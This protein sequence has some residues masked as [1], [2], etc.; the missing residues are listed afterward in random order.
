MAG[1]A[2]LVALVLSIATA[3]SPLGQAGV[4]QEAA[5]AAGASPQQP[6]AAALHQERALALFQPV[7]H[8][9]FSRGC[10]TRDLHQVTYLGPDGS[11]TYVVRWCD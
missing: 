1:L 6:A 4:S 7:A 9:V 8:T 5:L 11:A 3:W 2:A 10:Q